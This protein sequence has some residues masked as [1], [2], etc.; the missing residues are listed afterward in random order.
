VAQRLGF[1]GAFGVAL[2]LAR[3]PVVIVLVTGGVMFLYWACP[4]VK[5]SFG[6]VAPGAII[7]TPVWLILTYAFSLYVTHM[8][9]YN[10][11]YG[12]LGGAVA[13]MVWMYLSGYALL[14]GAEL[15]AT[16]ERAAEPEAFERRRTARAGRP[17]PE[18][19][20]L[21]GPNRG[22]RIARR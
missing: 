21:D 1:E 19:P 4:T 22:R 7:F 16:L 5:L 8:G 12:A 20:R 9:A 18:A 14:L 10:A 15:N 13:V 17:E 11:T 6:R 3:W 2:Q